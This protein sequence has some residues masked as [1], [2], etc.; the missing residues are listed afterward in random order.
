MTKKANP[1][2]YY[3]P[4]HWILGFGVYLEQLEQLV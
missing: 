1:K 3:Y 4:H 2:N